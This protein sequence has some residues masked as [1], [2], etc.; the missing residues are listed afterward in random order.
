LLEGFLVDL[1]A[2]LGLTVPNQC[3][4]TVVKGMRSWL[5]GDILRA[6][7]PNHRDPQYTVTTVLYDTVTIYCNV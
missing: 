4:Q 2:F 1:M 3:Y 7:T 5:L 6:E